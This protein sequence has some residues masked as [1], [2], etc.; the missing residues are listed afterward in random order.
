[1]MSFQHTRKRM[2]RE[3]AVFGFMSKKREVVRYGKDAGIHFDISES[4]N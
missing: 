3:G 2:R 1:M 4:V